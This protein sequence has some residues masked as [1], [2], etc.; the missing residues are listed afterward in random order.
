MNNKSFSELALA[1]AEATEEPHHHKTSFR[2]KKKIFATLDFKNSIA[3]I[4]FSLIDQSTFVAFGKENIYPVPGKWG[5]QGW[6]FFN[7]MEL[8]DDI[9]R[10]AVRVGYCKVAPSKLGDKYKDDL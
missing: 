6:T 7:I 4:K 10:D 8:E 3:C 2:V 5:Q 9:I 1:F